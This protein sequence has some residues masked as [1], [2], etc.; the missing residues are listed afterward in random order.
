MGTMNWYKVRANDGGDKS[1]TYV[2]CSPDSPQAIAD[3]AARGEYIRLEQLLYM[4][5]GEVKDFSEWDKSVV[6]TV[7]IN[8]KYIYAF[9]QF[10]G[11]PRVTPRK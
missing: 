7:H 4:D 9:M 6:S 2:G 1:R 11:D 3:K 5:R 8:P 10:K